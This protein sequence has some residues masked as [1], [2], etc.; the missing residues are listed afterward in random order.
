MRSSW[1]AS[2]ALLGILSL[3]GCGG[4]PLE[5]PRSSAA[6][7][8]TA[9]GLGFL[10]V[11]GGDPKGFARALAPRPFEF[12]ADYGSHPTFRTE[13]WYFTGNVF[14]SAGRHYGFELT[15]F[16]Y[17]LAPAPPESASRWATNQV[18]MAHFAV[19][20]TQGGRLL[21]EQRLSRGALGLA[22]AQASPFRVWVEDWSAAAEDQGFHLHARGDQASLD[23]HLDPLTPPIANG[24][25]GLDRKG[26]EPGNASYYYSV[27]KLAV[28]GTIAAGDKPDSVHGF[29]WIDREWST[30]A[31]SKGDVGWDWFALQLADGREIMFYRLRRRNGSASPFSGGS[32]ID[33]GGQRLSL[34]ES[35]VQLEP[36]EY[37]TSNKSGARYPVAWRVSIPKQALTLTVRPYL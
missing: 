27:P 11:G 17:A 19:T 34:D 32:L 33:A 6:D 2:G 24:D 14:D 7:P 29:A 9:T 15:F 13:W 28:S 21:A 25:R 36:L 37:W 30:S 12:P 1:K 18:W 35:D 31:L 16:R 26:P 8:S 23:L 3:A 4:G 5:G 20:D 22:G 10:G